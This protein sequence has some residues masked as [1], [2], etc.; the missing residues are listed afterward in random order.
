MCHIWHK[1]G[2]QKCAIFGSKTYLLT[3]VRRAISHRATPISLRHLPA[4]RLFL[5]SAETSL[6]L[7][8]RDSNLWSIRATSNIILGGH[9]GLSHTYLN[10]PVVGHSC[11]SWS[12]TW[13]A[14]LLYSVI[15]ADIT[16]SFPR[17]TITAVATPIWV[18][19]VVAASPVMN[20]VPQNTSGPTCI[21]SSAKCRVVYANIFWWP[22]LAPTF[23][24]LYFSITTYSSCVCSWCTTLKSLA[25]FWFTLVFVCDIYCPTLYDIVFSITTDGIVCWVLVVAVCNVLATKSP[26]LHIPELGSQSVFVGRTHLLMVCSFRATVTLVKLSNNN[27]A[28]LSGSWLLN[29]H[30]LE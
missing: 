2:H 4:M 15:V 28:K 1:M 11:R 6:L 27:F 18:L 23:V 12:N 30:S 26:F 20:L 3:E 16:A 29:S 10:K 19:T 14:H 5:G 7:L 22:I 9:L 13:P 24:G 25:I 21:V 8:I 17:L